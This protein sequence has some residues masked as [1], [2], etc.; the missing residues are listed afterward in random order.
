MVGNVG[1]SCGRC[2][3]RRTSPLRNNVGKNVTFL[4]PKKKRLL[5]EHRGV[6]AKRKCRS[7]SVS[8]H[9]GKE[10]G[11]DDDQLVHGVAQDVLHHGPGDERLVAA[12]RFT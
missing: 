10:Q 1:V 9:T 12:V 4:A 6:T 2:R 5:S 3:C 7:S 11:E 8:S